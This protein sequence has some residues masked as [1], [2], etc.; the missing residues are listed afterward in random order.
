MR[1][2]DVW[3]AEKRCESDDAQR[4]WGS[5][6]LLDLARLPSSTIHQ[7]PFSPH[8][9]L[10]TC[11]PFEHFGN[12]LRSIQVPQQALQLEMHRKTP[13]PDSSPHNPRSNAE[14]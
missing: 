5:S 13:S 2:V 7:Q 1:K 6:Y 10:K 4:T 3:M 11:E 12:F 14:P 8:A 9:K